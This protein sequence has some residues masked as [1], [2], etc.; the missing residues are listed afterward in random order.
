[1]F[2]FLSVAAWWGILLLLKLGVSR[3]LRKNT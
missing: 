1:M 2:S 3:T